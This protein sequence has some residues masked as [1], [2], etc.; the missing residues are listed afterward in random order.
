[1]TRLRAW[2][3]VALLLA[4]PTHSSAQ[5]VFHSFRAANLPTAETLPAGSWL[6]EISHRFDTPA[7][8]GAEALWGLDG[9]AVIRLGLSYAASDRVMLGLLRSNLR[10]NMELNARL[11]AYEGHLGEVPVEVALMGGAAWNTEVFEDPSHGAED[12]EFQAYAQLVLNAMLGGR[13]ALGLVPSYIRNPRIRDFEAANGF[14]LGLYGQLYLTDS[15]SVLGE[16]LVAEERADLAYD[17]GTFGFVFETRGHFFKLLAS[18]QR[19][20]NPSQ[21][22]GGAGAPFEPDEWRIGFNITRLLPF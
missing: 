17:A 1:M 2:V 3:G 22:L 15:V 21:F 19:R 5:E 18:N 11:S 7:S 8:F 20:L 13:F 14:A 9:P 6:F 12:N 4:A 16:W 10:D